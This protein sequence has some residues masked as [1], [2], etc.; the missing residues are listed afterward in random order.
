[1]RH[2]RRRRRRMTTPRA[3]SLGI[4]VCAT[5]ATLAA[6]AAAGPTVVPSCKGSDLTGA[7][8][9][10]P[11]SAGAGEHPLHP[12]AAEPVVQTLLRIR[13]TAPSPPRQEQARSPDARQAGPSRAAQR[14]PPGAQARRVRGGDRPLLTGRARP[15]R[16]IRRAPVRAQGVF[17]AG[18]AAGWDRL[19]R[20]PTTSADPGLRARRDDADRPHL[21]KERPENAVGSGRRL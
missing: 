12:S 5:A 2:L 7:F 17:D 1:M 16:G 14:R 8:L 4:A 21:R 10:V 15:R 19:G 18:D 3:L 9:V 13:N 20:R 6:S 11:G